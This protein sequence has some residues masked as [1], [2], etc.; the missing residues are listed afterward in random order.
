MLTSIKEAF[1]NERYYDAVSN[2]INSTIVD[3]SKPS[4]L[5]KES[6][7]IVEDSYKDIKPNIDVL[8]QIATESYNMLEIISER[9]YPAI[10]RI[11][12][13][14]SSFSTESA[15]S[16]FMNIAAEKFINLLKSLVEKIINMYNILI[17][18]MKNVK[19][20]IFK[21]FKIKTP[22]E[23]NAISLKRFLASKGLS[24]MPASNIISNSSNMIDFKEVV[25]TE[26]KSNRTKFEQY[27]EMFKLENPI[28]SNK[29]Y[30]N[31]I[32]ERGKILEDISS[33]VNDFSS[34][35]SNLIS[36]YDK[37]KGESVQNELIKLKAQ[38]K[39]MITTF[40]NFVDDGDISAFV[41]REYEI[42][43][44]YKSELHQNSIRDVTI[45]RCNDEKLLFDNIYSNKRAVLDRVNNLS[46]D[47]V[48]SISS[49]LQSSDINNKIIS[50]TLANR[51][52]NVKD[53]FGNLS[54]DELLDIIIDTSKYIEDCKNKYTNTS[55]FTSVYDSLD[56]ISKESKTILQSYNKELEKLRHSG[57]SD[58]ED[59]LRRAV[60]VLQSKMFADIAYSTS[61]M[62]QIIQTDVTGRYYQM[63]E[64]LNS[65]NKILIILK[66]S[67][68]KYLEKNNEN[69]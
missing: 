44:A 4:D 49:P 16:D 57:E 69:S 40:F 50:S 27:L 1:N 32:K 58:T 46:S 30:L 10:D 11:K 56:K 7:V 15:F 13:M 63:I 36:N 45:N 48:F 20:V 59:S 53:L 67:T 47:N 42:I 24:S 22:V 65:L 5:Q 37:D 43:P 26:L 66:D 28:I 8:N 12:T 3:Y 14:K 35:S 19:N 39:K 29:G 25:G 18:L 21:L 38:L 64:M 61:A 68:I 62:C 9:A 31:R 17:G 41:I 51:S 52:F 60:T 33:Y 54:C 34:K 23:K 55:G 6:K 2:N